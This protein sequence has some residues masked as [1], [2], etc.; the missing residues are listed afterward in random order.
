MMHG[1][2]KKKVGHLVGPVSDKRKRSQLLYIC[3]R[4]KKKFG[5]RT[6]PNGRV[7]KDAYSEFD[8]EHER[9]LKIGSLDHGSERA[10]GLGHSEAGGVEVRH[11]RSRFY[12]GLLRCGNIFHEFF[13]ALFHLFVN[14]VAQCRLGLGR[15]GDQTIVAVGGSGVFGPR[16]RSMLS[17]PHYYLQQSRWGWSEPTNR[18]RELCCWI[19]H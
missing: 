9:Y 18:P 19:V 15:L 14:G 11:P 8:G 16:C 13:S 5:L 10:D 4:T 6:Y 1:G 2:E 17:T 7:E 3:K 12:Q